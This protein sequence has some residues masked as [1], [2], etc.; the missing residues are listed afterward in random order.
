MAREHSHQ[1]VDGEHLLLATKLLVG[2]FKP[3]DRIKAV[4]RNGAVEFE[5]K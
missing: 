1:E 5:K 2:E 3:G 4:G